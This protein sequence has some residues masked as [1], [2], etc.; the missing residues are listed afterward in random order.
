MEDEPVLVDSS[1]LKSVVWKDFDRIRFGDTCVAVCK[2]CQKKLSGSSTS[3]TSHLRNHLVRCRRRLN[4]DIVPLVTA[5]GKKKEATVAIAAVSFDQEQQTSEVANIVQPKYEHA[6]SNYVTGNLVKSNFDNKRSRFDLARM[7]ILHGYPLQ[8]VEDVGFKIFVRNLQPLFELVTFDGVEGDC[9]QIYHK[10]KQ[11]VSDMLDKLPGKISLSADMWTGK[12]DAKYLCL[13]AHCIDDEWQLK[14]KIL[15]FLLVDPSHTEDMLSDVIMMSLMEWDIDRKLF[16]MTFD[17]CP[18]YDNIICKIRDQLRL[19]QNNFLICDGQLF[20][21]RCAANLIKNMAQDALEAVS[22]VTDKIRESIRHVKSSQGTQEKFNEMAQ[23]VGINSQKCLCLDNSLQWNS[24]YFMLDMALEFKDAFSLLP[25]HDSVYTSCPSYEEWDRA[26]A[27][28]SY[29]KLLIEVS[30]VFT[31]SK[32]VT[33]NIYFPEICEIHMQLIGWCHKSDEFISSLGMKMKTKFDDYWKKC[34]L[35]L[36]IAAILD[37]RFKMKLIE[38]YYPQIYGN[39]APECI[40]IVSNC[41][42]ALYNGHLASDGQAGDGSGNDS[43]DRLIG[44]DRFLHETSQG[45]NVKSDLDKYLEEPLFPRNME[46]NILN[47]WKVHT[48]R[49]P[50][51]STMALNILGIPMSKVTSDSAFDVGDR[52]LDPYWSLLR[53]NTVQALMCARDWMQNDSEDT[54][55]LADA[56]P[57]AICYDTS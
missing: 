32:H 31:G 9:M 16:S 5:K 4:H 47:W 17:S 38:Y 28:A 39:S 55:T 27:I 51:L 23:L 24:T 2:H 35:A 52:V 36:A 49:Y 43:R 45:P 26:S 40:D 13:T 33:A 29:L 48:P 19:S 8:M 7:I 18:T 56:T 34:S 37:P 25:E 20:E 11:K 41:M 10:E 57:L 14:K 50:I 53:S 15:N 30:N 21:V 1:R 12:G 46:F 54:K 44:F 42:K 22:E 6:H 3:G